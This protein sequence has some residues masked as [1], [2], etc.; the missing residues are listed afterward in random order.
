MVT[1]QQRKEAVVSAHTAVRMQQRGIPAN[2][3]THVFRYGRRI[4]AKG[5][6]FCVIGRKEVARY[7]SHGID[8]KACEGIH[9]LIA[10]NG[11]V[12]TIYRNHTLHGIR[13]K[14]EQVSVTGGGSN[15][16]ITTKDGKNSS[17]AINDSKKWLTAKGRYAPI[18][19][20]KN[21]GVVYFTTYRHE[22]T[23]YIEGAIFDRIEYLKKQDD[24]ESVNS[25]IESAGIVRVLQEVSPGTGIVRP[26]LGEDQ[27]LNT[28]LMHRLAEALEIPADMFV[29]RA[30]EAVMQ[31][32]LREIEKQLKRV[33]QPK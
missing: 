10:N 20:K 31:N 24:E 4:H 13:S 33:Q 5:L 9:A 30:A 8:L 26:S 28:E 16:F 2:A 32:R 11:P 23:Q 6:T 14:K 18:V 17:I 19:N 3:V 7:A 12:V 22:L 29:L 27:L 21:W 1:S 15:I 25:R